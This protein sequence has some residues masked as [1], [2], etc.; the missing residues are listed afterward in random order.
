VADKK[1]AIVLLSGGLDSTT[2]LAIAIADGFTA[3]STSRSKEAT[4]AL[5]DRLSD[6]LWQVRLTA[7]RAIRKV[8]TEECLSALIDQFAR[9]GGR[10]K[11]EFH[12]TLKVIARDDLGQ[13]PQTWQKWWRKQQE[14]YGGLPPDLPE[15][16]PNPTDQRYGKPDEDLTRDGDPSYYGKRFFSHSVCFVLD[17]SKSMRITMVVEPSAAKQLGDIPLS[18]ARIE[19]ARRA[20]A[21]SF[22]RL[23]PRTRIRLVFFDTE[24]KLWRR[25]LF[26]ANPSNV[27]AAIDAMDAI[28]PSGETNFYGAIRA[29]MGI[30]RGPSHDPALDPIPD[31]VF[32]L[33]D[34]RP[35]RGEIQTMP[36]LVQWMQNLNRFAKLKMHVIALGD[37]NVDVDALRLLAEAGSGEL[38]WVPEKR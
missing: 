21:D 19:I 36:E 13:N 9:E 27:Q 20:L 6:R 4:V 34:G 26:P 35:T 8:G 28:V 33:T 24:V 16:K 37:L 10:L 1:E 7:V 32:F 3:L 5:K 31:T 2:T 30:R 11:R 15:V 23:D 25:T 18:G 38:I 14:E 22:R 17:K 12:A 29:A